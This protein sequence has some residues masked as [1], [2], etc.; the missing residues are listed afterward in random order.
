[1]LRPRLFTSEKAASDAWDDRQLSDYCPAPGGE[2][3]K[4]M[5]LFAGGNSHVFFKSRAD[6]T[7]MLIVGPLSLDCAMAEGLDST[8][9]CAKDSQE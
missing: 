6:R 3:V 9:D 1:M 8:Y 4:V 7:R 2:I 5:P